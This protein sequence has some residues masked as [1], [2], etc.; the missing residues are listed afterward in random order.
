M[1]VNVTEAFAQQF[2]DNFMHVAQETESVL[3]K[4]ATVYN[5]IVGTSRS[6]NRL[7]KRTAQRVTTRHQDSPI[8]DQPHSTRYI[9]LYDWIDGDI[10]DDADVIRMLV[11][12]QSD[13]VKAM[14]SA[15]NRA[16]DAEMLRAL[17]YAARTGASTTASM[18]AANRELTNAVLNKAKMIAAREYFYAND[19]TEENGEELYMVLGSSAIGDLLTD[20]NLSTAEYNSISDWHNGNIKQGKAMGFSLIHSNLVP[21]VTTTTGPGG[22]GVYPATGKAIYAF[23]KSGLAL[24]IGKDVNV[25]VG[26]DPSKAFSTRVLAK[27]SIGAVRVEEEK[28]YEIFAS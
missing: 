2:A 25:K 11:D 6:I 15:M 9:D 24:G 17:G 27:M 21:S 28:V 3:K 23:A 10:I 19:A 12:P 26:E 22:T 4:A 14:V 18:A 5:N 1:S 7:G 20:T 13:Y 16:Q 8:N